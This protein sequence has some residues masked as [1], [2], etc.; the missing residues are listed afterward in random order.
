E[1]SVLLE[2]PLGHVG[3]GVEEAGRVG[4]LLGLVLDLA[5]MDLAAPGAGLD[6]SLLDELLEALEVAFG[7]S[8]DDAQRLADVLHGA[9]GLV[10]HGQGDA[11]ATG[12]ERLE[13]DASGVAGATGAL[14]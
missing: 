3:Y 7:P 10:V 12:L 9:F 13:H 14:P 1:L 5:A 11:G 4:D 2:R 6:P 8:L